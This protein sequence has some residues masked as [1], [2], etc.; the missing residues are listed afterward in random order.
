MQR[1]LRLAVVVCF[2]ALAIAVSSVYSCKCFPPNL[3][4]SYRV[5]DTIIIAEI[6]SGPE[7]NET[8][9]VWSGVVSSVYKGCLSTGEAFRVASSLHSASCGIILQTEQTFLLSGTWDNETDL[10]WIHTCGYNVLADQLDQ[11]ET[12]FLDDAFNPCT[13]ECATGSVVN[14]IVEPCS[15]SQCN[16]AGAVCSDNYCNGCHAYWWNNNQR[17]C[18]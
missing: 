8:T 17:V 3:Y 1:N 11:N 18:F 7:T 14:C 9:N 12:L 16:V 10:L 15:V 4:S 6:V 5:F 2:F 13:L